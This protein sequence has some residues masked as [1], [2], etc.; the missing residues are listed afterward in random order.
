MQIEGMSRSEDFNRVYWTDQARN[1]EAY[2]TTTFWRG[3]ELLKP[4]IRS[5]NVREI[6]TPAV[7]A[8]SFLELSCAFAVN[9]HILKGTFRDLDFPKDAV[10]VSQEVE[11]V[12]VKMIWGTRYG[13]PASHL[14]QT[15]VLTFI[16]RVARDQP[17]EELLPTYEYLC[18]VAHPSHIGNTRFWSHVEAVF[19]DGSERRVISR[20][21]EGVPSEEILDRILWSLGWSAAALRRGFE[22]TRDSLVTLLSKVNA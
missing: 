17:V 22:I 18:D 4:A 3:M 10:V 15:N 21:A 2:S 14:K 1:V 12:I 8:R 13:A 5:L 6:I 9:A 7:L 20:H 19:P 11:D 16:Q